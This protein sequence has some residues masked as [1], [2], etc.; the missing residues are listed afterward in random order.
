MVETKPND[1]V[2]WRI[3]IWN[4]LQIVHVTN[5]PD[6]Q[7][8]DARG[9]CQQS[10]RLVVHGLAYSEASNDFTVVLSSHACV[11]IS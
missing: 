10:E 3:T 11:F 7:V 9:L 6:M 5:Y 8:L 4:L 1:A 2:S